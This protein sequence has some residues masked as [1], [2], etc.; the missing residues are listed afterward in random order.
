MKIKVKDKEE[1]R[2]FRWVHSAND[3]KSAR[4]QLR[5]V[6]KH[7]E[8]LV[9][10]DGFRIHA[11]DAEKALEEMPD[12]FFEPE[13]VYITK[14][15]IEGEEPIAFGMYKYL[16]LE[17]VIPTGDPDCEFI[18]NAEFL[19]A[20]IADAHIVRIA[21]NNQSGPP[22]LEIATDDGRYALIMGM[23]DSKNGPMSIKEGRKIV[24]KHSYKDSEETDDPK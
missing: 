12:M 5:S 21:Y 17:Q 14:P 7:N 2:M 6:C 8:V 18:I 4:F 24:L 3:K 10:T 15:E 19:S 1:R 9:G 22:R 20:A 11:W 13:K 16:P 23:R